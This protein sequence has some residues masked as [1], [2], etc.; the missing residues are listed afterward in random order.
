MLRAP[1]LG[2]ADDISDLTDNS[3][4]FTGPAKEFMGRMDCTKPTD[5][6]KTVTDGITDLTDSEKPVQTHKELQTSVKSSTD[7]KEDRE[8]LAN[9]A[10]T[11]STLASATGSLDSQPA[12]AMFYMPMPRPRSYGSPL[13]EGSNVSEFFRRYEQDCKDYHL[14]AGDRLERLPNYCTPSIARTVRSMKP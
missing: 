3:T 7:R 14:S 4:D 8:P 2:L 1:E 12:T 11:A 6:R 9:I 13:F 5:D 10:A